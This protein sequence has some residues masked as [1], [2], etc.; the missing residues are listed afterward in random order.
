[1]YQAFTF[2][3]NFPL[4]LFYQSVYILFILKTK[5]KLH[6]LYLYTNIPWQWIQSFYTKCLFDCHFNQFG[7]F[8][9]IFFFIWWTLVRNKKFILF[10]LF[11]SF[12]P[13]AV[14]CC[15]SCP[16]SNPWIESKMSWNVLAILLLWDTMLF[17]LFILLE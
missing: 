17:I 8:Y 6:N 3:H 13:Y 15:W 16:C 5:L 2:S 9:F 10:I 4:Y 1:M 7:L 14:C 11:L 12:F